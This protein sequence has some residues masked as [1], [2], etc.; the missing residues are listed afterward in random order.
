MKFNGKVFSYYLLPAVLLADGYTIERNAFM[1]MMGGWNSI[2][3]GVFSSIIIYIL[4]L[5]FNDML[6]FLWDG[7]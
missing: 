3:Y 5:I 1:K 2:W 4:M 7:K 6:F